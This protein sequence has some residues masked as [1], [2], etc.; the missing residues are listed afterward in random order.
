MSLREKLRSDFGAA[1]LRMAVGMVRTVEQLVHGHAG[2]HDWFV[3]DL[4]QPAERGG[5]L[6][7]PFRLGKGGVAEH[8]GVD[9]QC[10]GE[11]PLQGEQPR[12]RGVPFGGN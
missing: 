6:A 2:Q 5:A 11:L 1:E 4:R 8:V 7:V 12:G 9:V 3:A 10:R